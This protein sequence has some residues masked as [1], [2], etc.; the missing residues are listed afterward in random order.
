VA[1]AAL[2]HQVGSNVERAYARSDLLE[3]RQS[4]MKDWSRRVCAN[5]IC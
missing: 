4:L 3:R 5:L 2:A 1:E